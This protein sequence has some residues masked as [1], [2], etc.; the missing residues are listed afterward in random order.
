[1]HAS[2]GERQSAF[3]LELLKKIQAHKERADQLEMRLDVLEK[4]LDKSEDTSWKVIYYL[5]CTIIN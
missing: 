2:F 3:I 1:M 4:M 5:C